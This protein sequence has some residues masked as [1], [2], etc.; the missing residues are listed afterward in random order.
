MQFMKD[1]PCDVNLLKSMNPFSKQ[2]VTRFWR[3]STL[4]S[5]L[6]HSFDGIGTSIKYAYLPTP[7]IKP[8]SLLEDL[9]NFLVFVNLLYPKEFAHSAG[10]RN[11]YEQFDT[12]NRLFSVLKYFLSV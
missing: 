1:K 10:V 9:S 5:R 4:V 3:V 11:S 8:V 12:E 6:Y 2:D 7:M